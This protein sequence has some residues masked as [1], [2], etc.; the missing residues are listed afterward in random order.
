MNS[1]QLGYVYLVLSQLSGW[2]EFRHQND[3]FCQNLNLILGV[4]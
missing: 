3:C 1:T 4:F 2:K